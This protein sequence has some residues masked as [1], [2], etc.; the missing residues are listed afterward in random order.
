M[1]RICCQSKTRV[2]LLSNSQA[3]SFR[4]P[5]WG[6]PN[7]LQSTF[8]L[9]YSV[10]LPTLTCFDDSGT[11]LLSAGVD[12]SLTI[13]LHYFWLAQL[14]TDSRFVFPVRMLCQE[15]AMRGAAR[16]KQNTNWH[17][18]TLSDKQLKLLVLCV[19]TWSTKRHA[20]V[21]RHTEPSPLYVDFDSW[22][23]QTKL[24]SER[25][26]QGK[27]PMSMLSTLDTRTHTQTWTHTHTHTH[28]NLGNFKSFKLLVSRAVNINVHW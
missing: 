15:A 17:V 4:V 1:V 13:C 10:W 16:P 23:K 12:C 11:L 5:F 26:F 6:K 25:C 19:H 28:A 3:F 7:E 21:L 2:K 14:N 9:L 24:W 18:A 20:G 22:Y 8:A 27:L